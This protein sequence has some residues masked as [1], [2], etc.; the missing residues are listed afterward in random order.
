MTVEAIHLTGATRRPVPPD[1]RAELVAAVAQHMADVGAGRFAPNPGRGCLR[2]P[3]LFACPGL[4][5]GGAFVR[6][7]LSRER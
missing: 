4:P 1:K 3:H 5:A 6:H 7:P 2:C